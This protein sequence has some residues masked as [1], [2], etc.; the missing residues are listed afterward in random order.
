MTPRFRLLANL[1]DG[2]SFSA[3]RE[4]LTTWRDRARLAAL[5]TRPVP[6]GANPDVPIDLSDAVRRALDTLSTVS[7]PARPPAVEAIF[8]KAARLLDDAE[9][10]AAA[11]VTISD[12]EIVAKTDSTPPAGGHWITLHPGGKRD[13]GAE[14]FIHVYVENG[15][16][17]KGP[18]G[19]VGKS[20][21]KAVTTAK[22][23]GPV[24]RQPVDLSTLPN[25]KASYKGGKHDGKTFAQVW[26]D[27]PGYLAWQAGAG[28]K[29]SASFL[30]AIPL[31]QTGDYTLDFGKYK[32]KTVSDVYDQDPSYLEWMARTVDPHKAGLAAS[33]Y[34]H[35]KLQ[36][37]ESLG[38][39]DG[40]EYLRNRFQAIPVD[41]RGGHV[42][43]FGQLPDQLRKDPSLAAKMVPPAS[44]GATA[45]A[46][47]AGNAPPD[48]SFQ[49]N[50]L[51]SL[52][53]HKV[54]EDL[55]SGLGEKPTDW[56]DNLP[57]LGKYGAQTIGRPYQA[58]DVARY[59]AQLRQ[60]DPQADDDSHHQ[61]LL[62]WAD[63]FAAAH[64]TAS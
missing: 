25:G 22:H 6:R 55:R 44:G 14:H 3:A 30:S 58:G 9:A 24:V 49:T 37:V 38:H 56:S 18:S 52:P 5:A 61:H 36:D 29:A 8:A 48:G 1:D 17:T 39:Y 11:A 51:Q 41:R 31:H 4:A 63:R 50:P 40:A 64:P 60:E 19:L 28:S 34:A 32:G 12:P 47:G 54:L 26:K 23:T 2:G 53:T 13:D 57:S 35:K 42:D 10:A 15:Q 20:L 46:N 43:R 27:D 21:G 59:A 33:F 7:Q 16:V 62:R 45:P